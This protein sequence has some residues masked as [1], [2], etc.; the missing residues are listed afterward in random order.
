VAFFYISLRHENTFNSPP[1]GMIFDRT[2][3]KHAGELPT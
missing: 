3:L 1:S 2:V